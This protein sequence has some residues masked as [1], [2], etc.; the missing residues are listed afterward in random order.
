[1]SIRDLR[2]SLWNI[3]YNKNEDN[4]FKLPIIVYDKSV[5]DYYL[6]IKHKSFKGKERTSGTIMRM[7][8]IKNKDT[9]Y[10]AKK[11]LNN[12]I[13]R[14]LS[15]PVITEDIKQLVELKSNI[16]KLNNEFMTLLN[17]IY[18]E[19]RN[20]KDFGGYCDFIDCPRI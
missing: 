20:K 14:Y 16:I 2:K 17:R 9:V 8:N 10:N 12:F 7:V 18:T 19:I 13:I 15:E 3:G 11:G 6:R 5:N 4:S 1:M